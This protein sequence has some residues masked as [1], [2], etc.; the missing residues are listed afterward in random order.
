M[1]K[2]WLKNYPTGVPAEINPNEYPSLTA[3]LEDN[4]TRFAS[5]DAYTSLGRTITYADYDRLARY[6]AA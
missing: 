2:V 4:C 1:N 6:F 5:L 3:L